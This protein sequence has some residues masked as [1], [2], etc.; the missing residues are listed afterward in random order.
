MW[1]SLTIWVSRF[2]S[3]SDPRR[4][5]FDVERA[6]HRIPQPEWVVPVQQLPAQ[7]EQN[8]SDHRPGLVGIVGDYGLRKDCREQRRNRERR[9]DEPRGFLFS[10]S[11]PG[12]KKRKR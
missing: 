1:R 10:E 12:R 9:R 4:W 11:L 3:M 6:L 5:R 2:L 7:F 8:G